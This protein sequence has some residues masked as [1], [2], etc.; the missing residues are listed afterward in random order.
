MSSSSTKVLLALACAGFLA[1]GMIT[2]ALGPALPELADHTGS[3]LGEIGAVFSALFLGALFAQGLNGLG[4]D[5]LGAR[6]FLLAGLLLL[7]GGTIG[8]TL[9]STLWLGLALAFVAGVGHG[10]VDV[11]VNVTI[12]N[13]FSQ[14]RA[15]AVNLVNVFFGIGAFIGPALA[16]LALQEW[17]S[18]LPSLWLGAGLEIALAPVFAVFLGRTALKTAHETTPAQRTKARP[19]YRSASLWLLG[20]LI[21]VY[22][23]IENGV[24][25]W[26]STYMSAT[27]EMAV[28][29]AA[30]VASGF[31]LAITLGRVV[32]S[33][34]G[35]RVGAQGLLWVSLSCA[36][37]GSLL[38]AAAS[39][40]AGWTVAGTV[41]LGMGF[42]PIFPTTMAITTATFP[43][44]PG[45]AASILVALGSLG[46]MLVPWG[47]GWV[48]AYGGPRPGAALSVVC[49]ALMLAFF[50]AYLRRPDCAEQTVAL[51]RTKSAPQSPGGR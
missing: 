24:G 25:G 44:S 36:L 13:T 1:L 30:L 35:V 49:A 11:A 6:R 47:M 31:W 45:T 43:H 3:S 19:V 42:G 15:S 20:G 12:S 38:I 26:I 34:L 10:I 48:L 51:R 17:N 22:V 23:G 37:G 18:A 2:A 41:L 29:Q 14:R 28:A 39:G 27:T 46:G 50:A 33:L 32:A 21:L 4:F 7:G 9:A 16:G 5:R 8:F 40:N